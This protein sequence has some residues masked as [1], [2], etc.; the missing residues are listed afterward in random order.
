MSTPEP[1]A[2]YRDPWRW[3]I[4]TPPLAA[5]LAGAVTT[6]LAIRSWDGL[7]VDDY[8]KQGL[9][10]NQ[11]LAR[12]ARAAALGLA[13]TVDWDVRT[14]Q[15][16]IAWNGGTA[17][18]R[19]AALD[20]RLIYATRE[21]L[22]RELVALPQGPGRYATTVAALRSGQWHVHVSAGDWRVTET[23]FVE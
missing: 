4:I 12:D 11:V 22:D 21:G 15:L 16:E 13:A 2:W 8:Y 3:L 9:A 23:L 14:G 17:Q 10:I 18:L 6:W 20:V 1:S 7:V 5:V 19:P